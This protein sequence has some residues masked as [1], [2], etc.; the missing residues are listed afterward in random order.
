MQNM[1]LRDE[2]KP[3]VHK[4][5]ICQERERCCPSQR[6]KESTTPFGFAFQ[7]SKYKSA[8]SPTDGSES[9]R[10]DASGSE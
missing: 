1:L 7:C 10:F 9:T 2:N 6:V 8:A 4:M 3:N 5:R